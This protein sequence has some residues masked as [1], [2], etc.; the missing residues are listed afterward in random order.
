MQTS[1]FFKRLRD[2]RQTRIEKRVGRALIVPE[3]EMLDYISSRKVPTMMQHCILKVNKKVDGT[4][5]EKFISAFNICTA[6]FRRYGY[7]RSAMTMT[8]RGVKRNRRHQ[9]EKEASSKKSRYNSLVNKLW[10]SSL[11]R[12]RQD[13]K[14]AAQA[15]RS[16]RSK[17]LVKRREKLKRRR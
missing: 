1:N 16:K 14:E 8:G 4:P 2:L 17:N 6:C 11:R 13:K 15:E 12:F 7:M 5:T 9:R 10:V 3:E